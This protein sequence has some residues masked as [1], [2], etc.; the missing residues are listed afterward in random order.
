MW[1]AVLIV[2]I[3]VLA[4]VMFK[5]LG[6]GKASPSPIAEPVDDA[7]AATQV[8]INDLPFETEEIANVTD[9]CYRL[10]FG[11][12]AINAAL[13]AEHAP[14][15]DAVVKSLDESVHERDYFP[16]RPMLLPKLLQT[17]NDD[18][19]TRDALVR[20]LMEDPTLAGAVLQ[21]ANS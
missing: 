18:E 9:E 14:V 8:V 2:L 13:I 21:R 12:P 6:P 11:L 5:I 1:I 19:S 15:L 20:V 16:R 4:A 7:F 10:A 3:A 17:L